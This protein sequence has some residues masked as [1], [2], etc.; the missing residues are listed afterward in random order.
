MPCKC[1]AEHTG[2]WFVGLSC[3]DAARHMCADGLKEV[4]SLWISV[5]LSLLTYFLPL[6]PAPVP[7]HPLMYSCVSQ[8]D[9]GGLPEMLGMGDASYSGQQLPEQYGNAYASAG[10]LH[11]QQQHDFG[12]GQWAA[13]VL[14]SQ[15]E[16]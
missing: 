14:D 10:G 15:S 12:S 1:I 16:S 5:L 9:D 6:L 2:C 13:P 8:H 11:F 3:V 4:S 7:S